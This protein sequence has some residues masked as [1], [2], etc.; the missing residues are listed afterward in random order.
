MKASARAV[1]PHGGG[2]QRPLGLEHTGELGSSPRGWGTG[3]SKA[4][5]RSPNR[6][7]PTG[8]G[9]R[10]GGPPVH[11]GGPV[12]PHGGGEQLQPCRGSAR[13]VGSSPRG[14]GTVKQV[15]EPLPKTRFIP[16]GVGNRPGPRT[17]T[18]PRPVH[19][20][21]GGE[22][23]FPGQVAPGSNGS[24]PR[25]WGTD[26]Q[27]VFERLDQRFIPTGVGNR[28]EV[29]CWPKINMVHPHGGGEQ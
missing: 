2:E 12:H 21:G 7:I 13:A 16:T 4:K 11:P 15:G 24:S 3:V 28:P 18:A 8:V 23:G 17:Q 27:D 1:H 22:Q 14:W 6:F 9:N 19:P 25:G 5:S 26:R 29:F 10:Q 20:H